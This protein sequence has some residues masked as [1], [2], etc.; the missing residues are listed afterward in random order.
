MGGPIK[1]IDKYSN[2]EIIYTPTR[3]PRK[4]IAKRSDGVYWAAYAWKKTG[5]ITTLGELLG[6]KYHAPAFDHDL[7]GWANILI[8]G[9]A[10][11]IN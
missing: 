1:R 10:Y 2:L 11:N 5:V 4:W 6:L 3:N 9:K 7:T 8:E